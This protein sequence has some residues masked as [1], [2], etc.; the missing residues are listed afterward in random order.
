MKEGRGESL[1]IIGLTYTPMILGRDSSS[2]VLASE[3]YYEKR[4]AFNYEP[5]SEQQQ[6]VFF[7]GVLEKNLICNFLFVKTICDHES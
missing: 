2:S 5:A 6:I 4:A 3:D 1:K 7:C